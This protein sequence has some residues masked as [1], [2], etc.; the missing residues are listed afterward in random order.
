MDKKETI[1]EISKY[2]N[3]YQKL[4]SNRNWKEIGYVLKCL[5]F[6]THQNKILFFQNKQQIEMPNRF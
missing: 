2:P 4:K 1:K 3:K 5:K 6:M